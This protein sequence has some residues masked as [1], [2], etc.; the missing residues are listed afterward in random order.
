MGYYSIPAALEK[1]AC[2]LCAKNGRLEKRHVHQGYH[3]W[4]FD[5]GTDHCRESH[6]TVDTKYRHCHGNR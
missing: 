6:S 4:Y 1:E 5:Q 2:L 3:H